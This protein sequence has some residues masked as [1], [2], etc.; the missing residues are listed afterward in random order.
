MSQEL[1]LEEKLEIIER[2]GSSKEDVLSILIDL[3]H[4][5]PKGYIDEETATLVGEKVG[6][7]LTKVYEIMTFYAMLKTKPQAK[8][9]LKICNSSPCLFSG[10]SGVTDT[11]KE[12][13]GVDVGVTTEDNLFAYHYI[14]CC[15]ACDIGPVIKIKDTVYGDLNEDKIKQLI[16]DLK[17]GLRDQ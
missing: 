13:L 7:T 14:P 17:Q 4:A 9:V 5:D 8:Y 10:V 12:L 15:G 2:N 11:L 16:D 1:T 3:Q 6:L